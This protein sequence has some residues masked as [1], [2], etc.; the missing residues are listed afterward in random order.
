MNCMGRQCYSIYTGRRISST[1]NPNTVPGTVNYILQCNANINNLYKRNLTSSTASWQLVPISEPFVFYDTA[2]EIVCLIN[3][4]ASSGTPT[5]NTVSAGAPNTVAA[6]ANEVSAAVVSAGLLFTP[7]PTGLVTANLV[8]TEP[9]ANYIT[10]SQLRNSVLYTGT[11]Q[12]N[13]THNPVRTP[14][15]MLAH[16]RAVNNSVLSVADAAAYAGGHALNCSIIHADNDGSHVHALA[17]D[18]SKAV[19]L[20][21]GATVAGHSGCNSVLQ[22]GG[23]PTFKSRNTNRH[24]IMIVGAGVVQHRNRVFALSKDSRCP[25]ENILLE[26]HAPHRNIPPLGCKVCTDVGDGD[27]N[28]GNGHGALSHGQSITNSIVH[29]A[30]DGASVLGVAKCGEVHAATGLA[31]QAFGRANLA[32]APYSNAIG[33]NSVS[34]LYGQHVQGIKGSH[35]T[36]VQEDCNICQ[37]SRVITHS[38]VTCTSVPSTADPTRVGQL[39][40]TYY[41]VTGATPEDVEIT[42]PDGITI[43]N[44]NLPSLIC[45]GVAGVEVEVVSPP[46]IGQGGMAILGSGEF[47][48]KYCFCVSRTDMNGENCHSIL[49]VSATVPGGLQPLPDCTFFPMGTSIPPAQL[50][51]DLPDNI[52]GG[53][54]ICFR[55]VFDL[56]NLT[57]GQLSR[58]TPTPTATNRLLTARTTFQVL[59]RIMCATFKWTQSP[60]AHTRVACSPPNLPV[61]TSVT[62]PTYVAVPSTN[63]CPTPNGGNGGP[64]SPPDGNESVVSTSASASQQT[65]T[66]C[67]QNNISTSQ[68][69]AGSDFTLADGFNVSPDVT[70]ASFIQDINQQY[71][72]H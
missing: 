32:L 36:N 38:H 65:C 22:A 34:H 11:L 17:H 70:A 55:E 66:K 63:I 6:G 12:I 4:P 62:V 39:I 18:Q 10:I 19:S 71:M 21:H 5:A 2:S 30:A 28:P 46:I 26:D 61:I 57:P 56:D 8:R 40:L 43:T 20:G 59:A 67:P 41:L 29:A 13:G 23:P 45:P 47:C 33:H 58:I 35:N 1:T 68:L 52:C 60:A 25:R 51:S 31:S 69:F 3:F 9:S 7:A 27:H 48:A 53:F 72:G 24:R 54:T 44:Y 42:T 15:G 49:P 64:V 16:G 50:V 37:Y 14:S